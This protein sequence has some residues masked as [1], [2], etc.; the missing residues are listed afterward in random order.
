MTNPYPFTK[1]GWR[2]HL[3]LEFDA[4]LGV[5]KVLTIRRF[6]DND[7]EVVHDGSISDT[8][9]QAIIDAHI[10]I[11]TNDEKIVKSGITQIIIDLDNGA[12]TNLERLIRC[13]KT[14][15]KILKYL[16]RE[17]I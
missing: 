12:G 6:S 16:R 8:Q 9:I 15:V 3:H 10:P 4:A 7:G 17:N 2:H 13:E 1:L 14:L 11:E 5:G